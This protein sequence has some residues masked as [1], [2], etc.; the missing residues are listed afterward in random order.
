MRKSKLGDTFWE[1][2]INFVVYCLPQEDKEKTRKKNT[3]ERIKLGSNLAVSFGLLFKECTRQAQR[4]GKCHSNLAF[5]PPIPFHSGWPAY[6]MRSCS[7]RETTE[8]GTAEWT[9]GEETPAIWR[10]NSRVTIK[11]KQGI[12]P[13]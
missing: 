3:P 4:R 13:F 10:S 6:H 9:V 11:V 8:R 1:L 12:F 7:E 5:V 2:L